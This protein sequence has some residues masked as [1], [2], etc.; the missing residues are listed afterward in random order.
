MRGAAPICR[1]LTAFWYSKGFRN[2]IVDRLGSGNFTPWY[3]QCSINDNSVAAGVSR[4]V[5]RPKVG[6]IDQDDGI[7]GVAQRFQCYV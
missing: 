2:I 6:Y 4:A 1:A 5:D 7:D 3:E